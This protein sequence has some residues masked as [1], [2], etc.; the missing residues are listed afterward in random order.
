MASVS[1]PAS[2]FLHHGLLMG[3]PRLKQTLFSRFFGQCFS[4]RE[5]TR[6]PRDPKTGVSLEDAGAACASSDLT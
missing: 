3:D 6:T 4:T 1:I 5:Q 2:A